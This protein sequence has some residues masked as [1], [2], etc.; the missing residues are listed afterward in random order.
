MAYCYTFNRS[1]THLMLRNQLQWQDF[2]NCP[3]IINLDNTGNYSLVQYLLSC[4]WE[5]WLY[6]W[7]VCVYLAGR[8]VHEYKYRYKS[9]AKP[10][11]V[12]EHPIAPAASLSASLQAKLDKLHNKNKNSCM[13]CGKLFLREDQLE[14]HMRSHTSEAPFHCKHC[15]IQFR[16]KTN[17]NKHVRVQHGTALDITLWHQ[18]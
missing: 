7:G 8:R 5:A 15:G 10:L 3:V 11:P 16:N 4:L 18:S 14:I 13:K 12:M 6:W 9:K 17:M 1:G 2:F